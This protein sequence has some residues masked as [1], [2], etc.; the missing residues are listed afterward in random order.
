MTTIFIAKLDTCSTFLRP[1]QYQTVWREVIVWSEQIKFIE[2]FLDS[3][4][5]LQSHKS[6]RTSR[7]TTC[8]SNPPGTY[9]SFRL[10]PTE[11]EQ[12]LFLHRLIWSAVFF[13]RSADQLSD[14]YPTLNN[15]RLCNFLCAP[16]AKI[17]TRSVN[18]KI[19]ILGMKNLARGKF[20]SMSARADSILTQI[21]IPR[22][23]FLKYSN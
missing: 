2:G 11:T 7:K 15:L 8:K 12:T 21:L 13:Y 6:N 9:P 10:V 5:I 17:R 23:V 16:T 4:I 19:I 1:P 18:I 14:W 20:I 22:V 3:N